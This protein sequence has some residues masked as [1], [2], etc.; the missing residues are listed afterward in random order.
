MSDKVTQ[1]DLDNT[2]LAYLFDP[3]EGLAAEITNT[4]N[5]MADQCEWLSARA[6]YLPR[7]PSTRFDKAK[8]EAELPGK[9]EVAEAQLEFYTDVWAK[10]RA[11]CGEQVIPEPEP[12]VSTLNPLSD[13]LSDI[14]L[15]AFLT[16]CG[17]RT[18]QFSTD[19]AGRRGLA[20]DLI[21]RGWRR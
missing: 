21:S 1:L 8:E 9:V 12:K 20:E 11:A 18:G 4:L 13:L 10:I 19:Y 6:K 15:H 14:G 17:Q 3:D 7:D 5:T 16:S 2:L